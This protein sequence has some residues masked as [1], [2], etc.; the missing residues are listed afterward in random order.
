M[1]CGLNFFGD[2]SKSG[3]LNM[4]HNAPRPVESSQCRAVAASSAEF[5]RASSSTSGDLVRTGRCSLADS[6]QSVVSCVRPLSRHGQ[7]FRLS[8]PCSKLLSGGESASHVR[9]F[10]SRSAPGLASEPILR[11]T[12]AGGARRFERRWRGAEPSLTSLNGVNLQRSRSKPAV[13]CEGPRLDQKQGQSAQPRACSGR[14]RHVHLRWPA[15][16]D[17]FEERWRPATGAR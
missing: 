17:G 11:A 3:L 14:Q 9:S 15:R 10:R 13:P 7:R 4:T 5:L 6:L 1:L 16:V 12:V 2:L 8:G